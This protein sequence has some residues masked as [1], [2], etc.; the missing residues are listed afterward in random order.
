[1]PTCS[2]CHTEYY[3]SYERLEPEEPCLC[4]EKAWGSVWGWGRWGAV[5]TA[6]RFRSGMRL[7]DLG[8]WLMGL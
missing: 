1:M 3:R 5:L 4:G 6:L 8:Q 7:C 2:I